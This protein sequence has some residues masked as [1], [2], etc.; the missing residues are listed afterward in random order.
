MKQGTAFKE[1]RAQTGPHEIGLKE[2]LELWGYVY[3]GWLENERNEWIF[4]PERIACSTVDV[5][6][7]GSDA[8]LPV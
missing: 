7:G 3:C 4:E 1:H 2:I 6:G 5:I 8:I